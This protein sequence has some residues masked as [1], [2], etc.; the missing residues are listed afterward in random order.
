MPKLTFKFKINVVDGMRPKQI[1]INDGQKKDKELEDC[2]STEDPNVFEGEII[3]TVILTTVEVSVSGVGTLS[4]LTG[5]FNIT[6]KANDKK[7]FE[8]DQDLKVTDGNRFSFFKKQV[9]L[10]Q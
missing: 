8:E 10:P 3:A 7:L 2:Q 9:K 5:S 4:G 1:R 6:L